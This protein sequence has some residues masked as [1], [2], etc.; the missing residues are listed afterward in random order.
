MKLHSII[1]LLVVGLAL[2]TGGCG[3]V[4]S[5]P[6]AA[7]PVARDFLRARADR[8]AGT[9]YALLTAGAKEAISLD[10]VVGQVRRETVS[11]TSLGA[12]V[13]ADPGWVQVPVVDLVVRTQES[14][15]RWPEVRLTLHYEGG[16]WR[17]AWAD[18]LMYLASQAYQNARYSEELELAE[19]IADIDPYHYRG[20]L[21]RHFAQRSL[22]RPREAEVALLKAAAL[23][24]PAQAPD[25]ED[26]AARFRLRLGQ[27]DMAL[28]HCRSA[29]EKAAPYIPQL[30]SFRWQ[31]D[32]LAVQGRAFLA[33]GDRSAAEAAVRDGLSIDPENA[34]LAML[35]R[36]L[37]AKP[38]PPAAT[39]APLKP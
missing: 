10:A 18:P 30:Y 12:A 34:D 7:V 35:R 16:Q 11:F 22:E 15:A 20:P 3:T 36:D 5:T 27:P 1:A 33:K 37:A 21:E 4:P 31:A 25:V 24:T 17:V 9:L 32:A 6:D 14:E 38:A 23:A 28:A 19:S 13:Q 2:L 39:P 26:A 8:S 29:L